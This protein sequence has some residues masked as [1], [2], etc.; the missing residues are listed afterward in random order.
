MQS[1]PSQKR[2]VRALARQQKS[3][4]TI[5]AKRTIDTIQGRRNM[6]TAIRPRNTTG[7]IVAKH[8]IG[9]IP[10]EKRA[11]PGPTAEK[12]WHDRRKAYNRHHPRSR[13]MRAAAR[14]RNTTGT[15]VAKQTIGTIREEKHAGHDPPTY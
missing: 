15:I 14:L 12:H 4:G 6:R 3:T 9:T 13:N 10:E 7:T 1:A 8:A 2:N 11:G 5:A